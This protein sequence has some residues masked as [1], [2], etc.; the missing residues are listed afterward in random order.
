MSACGPATP[1]V[2]PLAIR[3]SYTAASKPWLEKAYACASPNLLDAQIQSADALDPSLENMTMRIGEPT[4]T[5]FPTYQIGSDAVEVIGNPQNPLKQLTAAQ[6]RDLFTGRIQNWKDL[7]GEAAPVE[8]WVYAAGEDI[9][10]LFEQTVL[11]GS[12]VTSLARMAVSPAE[13][14]AAVAKDANAVGLLTQAWKAEGVTNLLTVSTEPVL[15]STPSKPQ[16][17]ILDL[18]HCLQK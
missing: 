3:I 18:I 8:V 15:V 6:A 2:T 5:T 1:A 10:Q 14:A 9:Q 7:Q 12:P 11:Q 13:M 17:A 4:K 16:G